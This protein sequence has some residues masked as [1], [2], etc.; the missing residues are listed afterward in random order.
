MQRIEKNRDEHQ[1]DGNN[2][3]RGFASLGAPKDE[4]DRHTEEYGHSEQRTLEH[5]APPGGL[6]RLRLRSLPQLVQPVPVQASALPRGDRV[7]RRSMVGRWSARTQS[8]ARWAMAARQC[9]AG[10]MGISAR[11]GIALRSWSTVSNS[12]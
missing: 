12:T 4:A 6:I 5:A 3:N 9:C 11:S 7:M 10:F 1:A 2:D 8:P